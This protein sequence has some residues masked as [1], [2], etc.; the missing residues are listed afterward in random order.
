MKLSK[1]LT[2]KECIRSGTADR[3]GIDNTPDEWATE[4]LKKVAEHIFQP[5]RDHFGVPVYVSSGYRSPDLNRAI[6]GS[7]RS[8]HMEGRALDLDADVF[9]DISNAEIFH[10]IRECL[11]FDQVVWEFGDEDNPSWVHVS[12]VHGGPNR[13]RCLKAC[14]NS[15]GETYYEVIFE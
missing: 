15:K 2:L 7:K 8:Q 4:N 11:E 5:L 6:G 9:G 3:L 13:K 14:R 1:N 12:Y 10:Y